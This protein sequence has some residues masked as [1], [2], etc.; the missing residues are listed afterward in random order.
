ML[1]R[2][3]SPCWSSFPWQNGFYQ[4]TLPMGEESPYLVPDPERGTRQPYSPRCVFL[5]ELT[6]GEGLRG[7]GVVSQGW[8]WGLCTV[9]SHC[10]CPGCGHYPWL[11]CWPSSVLCWLIPTAA[12]LARQKEIIVSGLCTA[13]AGCLVRS[14]S[15]SSLALNHS[16]LQRKCWSIAWLTWV[17]YS[18][19]LNSE[20]KL[21]LN[22]TNFHFC[23]SSVS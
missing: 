17:E 16:Q 10:C 18:F 23:V 20:D 13:T 11:S 14:P 6:L 15:Q 21:N 5:Q 12:P 22:A 2:P 9:A 4:H 8:Y 1:H 7:P 3:L 19:P